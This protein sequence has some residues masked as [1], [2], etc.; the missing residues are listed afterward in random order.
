MAVIEV[1]CVEYGYVFFVSELIKL[2]ITQNG[3][4]HIAT[5]CASKDCSSNDCVEI[6]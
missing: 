3:I 1:K 6:R 5:Q 4:N 2:S